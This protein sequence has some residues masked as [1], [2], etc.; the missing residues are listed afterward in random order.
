M[1][2]QIYQERIFS[3]L[4]AAIFA[5]VV[6]G[7][8]F[9]LIYQLLVGPLGSRPASNQFLVQLILFFLAVGI[10]FSTLSIRINSQGVL[11]G[12]GLF[13]RTVQWADIE[14]CYQDDVSAAN[15]GGWG[16]RMG[17]VRGKWRLV[18]NVVGSPRVVLALKKGRFREFVFSTQRPREVIKIINQ[19]LIRK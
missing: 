4:N 19:R 7:L 2:K 18:Y 15:Y 3:R 5:V 1:T 12:Y 14:K 17:R 13:K 6:G 11:V 10:N 8:V 9:S 16:I